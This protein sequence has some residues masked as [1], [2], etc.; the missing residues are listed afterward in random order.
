MTAIRTSAV[1]G[2]VVW[3]MLIAISMVVNHSPDAKF[4]IIFFAAIAIRNSFAINSSNRLMDRPTIVMNMF[5]T[6]FAVTALLVGHHAF[7]R[8]GAFGLGIISVANV[9]ALS[10]G[11]QDVWWKRLQSSQVNEVPEREVELTR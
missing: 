5:L 1:V 8:F 6:M 3:A 4:A 11:K 9:F 7:D 10:V 2:N